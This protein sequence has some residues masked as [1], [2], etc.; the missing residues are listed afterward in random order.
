METKISI[1]ASQAEDG[2]FNLV[3]N[4]K[5]THQDGAETVENLIKSG[6]SLEELKSYINSL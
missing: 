1:A 6:L 2:T 5:V 3:I 4:K